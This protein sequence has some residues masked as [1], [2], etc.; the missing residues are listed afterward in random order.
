[1]NE[2]LNEMRKT[3]QSFLIVRTSLGKNI[4]TERRI[5]LLAGTSMLKQKGLDREFRQEKF[6]LYSTI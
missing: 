2:L 5:V 3:E 1:M 4:K 6:T